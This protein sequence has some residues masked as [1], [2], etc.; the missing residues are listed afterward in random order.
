M[1]LRAVVVG[2]AV[3]LCGCV[4]CFA[5]QASGPRTLETLLKDDSAVSTQRPVAIDATAPA[6]ANPLPS[7]RI[8]GAVARP[9]DGVQHPDLDKAWAEY[10]E[11]IETAA[12][13]IEQAIETELNK[14]AEAGDLD[15]ALKWKTA[16]EQFQK[17]GRL[18]E[19]LDGQRPQARPKPK[20]A[21][22]EPSPQSL[23]VEAQG[24]LAKAY[25]AVEKELVKSLDLQKAKQVRLERDGLSANGGARTRKLRLAAGHTA[26]HDEWR[27]WNGNASYRAQNGGVAFMPKQHG[28]LAAACSDGFGAQDVLFVHPANAATPAVLSFEEFTQDRKGTLIVKYRNQPL[29][30]PLGER[31]GVG[32][33]E[34]RILA[35]K[36][37][38]SRVRSKDSRW[39]PVKVAFDNEPVM[40]SVASIGDWNAEGLFLTY[41]IQDL[42]K[43]DEAKG[44]ETV[45]EAEAAEAGARRPAGTVARLKDGVQH[46]DLDKAWADYDAVVA[47]AAEGIRSALSKQFDAATA[48]GDLDAAERWQ[49]ALEK[50]EKAGE[51]PVET[52]TKAAVKSALGDYKKARDELSKAYG[53]VVK[54]LTM[55]KKI[56]EAT[57]ARDEWKS[58]AAGAAAPPSVCVIEAKNFIHSVPNIATRAAEEWDGLTIPGRAK[59]QWEVR[60][61]KA[62]KYF[63]HV[64]YSSERDRKCNLVVD[65]A[66]VVRGE[67]GRATGGLMRPNLQWATFGPFVFKEQSLLEIVPQ[68]Y[69]PHYDRLVVSETEVLPTKMLVGGAVQVVFLSDLKER[70]VSVGY[71]AYGKNGDLGYDGHRVSVQGV[72]YNKTVGIA[73][74]GDGKGKAVFDLPEGCVR[75]EATAAINDTA[76]R[77]QKTALIFRVYGDGHLLWSSKPLYGGG[78][79]EKCSL[80]LKGVKSLTLVVEC[81]GAGDWSHS[82]WLDPRVT[83]P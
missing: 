81:P 66:T 48:K 40:L 44:T 33:N 55:A 62:G 16:G 25:E 43:A 63:V 46:P 54:A 34:V 36:R 68:D 4:P 61:P 28:G 70:D 19:G 75:F 65:G 15:A 18:P 77:N 7:G 35:G 21:K 29:D 56:A 39:S 6:A 20:P 58:L 30:G 74:Y 1:R 83:L 82:V 72:K 59:L 13:A 22:P 69:G 41:E 8:R 5:Q 52:E 73:P 67:L 32:E 24:R 42:V 37:E 3:V 50:F 64:L 60:L 71:G 45:P 80:P 11:Q 51:V 49:T 23:V 12:K 14:A 38:V 76:R 57:A 10:D 31:G 79:S 9:K 27:M 47:Q 53:A 2:C 17:D 26:T 78:S